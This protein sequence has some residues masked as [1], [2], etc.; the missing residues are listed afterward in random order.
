MPVWWGLLRRG[1]AQ[2]FLGYCGLR[3]GAPA[4]PPPPL[5]LVLSLFLPPCLLLFCTWKSP[6]QE[7]VFSRPLTALKTAV[8]HPCAS[9]AHDL[10]SMVPGVSDPP[11]EG[12]GWGLLGFLG[13]PWP[14]EE[15]LAA[16]SCNLSGFAHIMSDHPS[17]SLRVGFSLDQP[18]AGW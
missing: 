7:V 14:Q 12:Q 5:V 17:P 13:S 3:L 6:W 2:P 18:M 10:K 15:G 9:S 11:Q 8:Q 4:S 16:L 1:G